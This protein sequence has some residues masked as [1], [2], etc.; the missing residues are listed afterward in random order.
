[1]R[2]EELEEL[3]QLCFDLN[4]PPFEGAAT[5]AATQAAGA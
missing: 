1:M 5:T 4:Q 3:N 2:A